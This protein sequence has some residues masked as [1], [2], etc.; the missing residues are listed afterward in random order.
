MADS[1]CSVEG[2]FSLREE[3]I[4]KDQDGQDREFHCLKQ[5]FLSFQIQVLVVVMLV[6]V[7]IQ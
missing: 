6:V 2:V 1:F 3:N 7:L 4:V 5:E